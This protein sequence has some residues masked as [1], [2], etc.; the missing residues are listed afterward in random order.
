MK[1]EQLPLTLEQV[2]E[3]ARK[4]GANVTFSLDPTPPSPSMPERL[5]N[6]HP[7]VVALLDESE[8]LTA[9]GHKWESATTPNPKGAALAFEMGWAH[10]LCGAW[11]RAYLANEL[12]IKPVFGSTAM[13]IQITQHSYDLL[14]QQRDGLVNGFKRLRTALVEINKAIN[15]STANPLAAI[16]KL[17]KDALEGEVPPPATEEPVQND[18]LNATITRHAPE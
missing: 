8:R 16:F 12:E 11:L 3:A 14:V 15:G 10:A 5:P 13:M 17:A 4:S 18:G 6:D 7:L 9:R 1:S 2:V